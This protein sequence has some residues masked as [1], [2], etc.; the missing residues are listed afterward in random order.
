MSL[1]KL[2]PLRR[3]PNLQGIDVYRPSRDLAP[4]QTVD[5]REGGPAGRIVETYY[6]P[7]A[8]EYQIL[9][10]F[11]LQLEDFCAPGDPASVFSVGGPTPWNHIAAE[12]LRRGHPP[13]CLERLSVS[14]ICML[15]MQQPPPT[16]PAVTA[17]DARDKWLYDECC[18]AVKYETIK[19]QLAEKKGWEPLDSIQGIKLAANRYA[20]AHDLSSIPSRQPGRRAHR[21]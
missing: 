21:K 18:K 19:R 6:L 16:S 7:T 17:N 1:L 10:S 13:A 2:Y 11:C 4:G 20:K 8:E 5:Y 14:E 9:D 12:L 15:V 3:Q